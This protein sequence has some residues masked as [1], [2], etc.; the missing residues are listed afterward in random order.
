MLFYHKESVYQAG[1]NPQV[2]WIKPFMIPEA[3]SILVPN[4]YLAEKPDS[5][6]GFASYAKQKNEEQ[7]KEV[8]EKEKAQVKEQQPKKE[9]KSQN[10]KKGGKAQHTWNETQRQ[11]GN[12]NQSNVLFY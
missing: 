4:S 12:Y 10:K 9:K 3:L 8:A 5:Y 2:L 7:E 6:T 1:I 11:Y